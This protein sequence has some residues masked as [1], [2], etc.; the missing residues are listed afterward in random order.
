MWLTMELRHLQHFIAVAE[1]LSFTNAA[2]RVHIVQS[3]L[4]ASIRSLERELGTELFKRTG[5]SVLLTESGKVLLV[6]ARKITQAV[7]AAQDAVAAV[8]GGLRG[9][10]RVGILQSLAFGDLVDVLVDFHSRRPQVRIETR[11]EPGGSR[12]LVKAV[13]D[14]HL[15]VAFVGLP[16]ESPADIDVAPLS[17]EALAVAVPRNHRLYGRPRVDIDELDGEPFVDYPPGWGIRCRVDQMFA[18][19]GLSR[20]IVVEIADCRTAFELALA[21]LGLAFV[22]P[23]SVGV[24]GDTL[25]QVTPA[26]PFEVSIITGIKPQPHAAAR[27]FVD[28]VRAH[29]GRAAA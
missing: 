13:Q 9:L 17:C 24:R 25:T 23:S 4:S 11:V 27:A 22:I 10:V 1:E 12:E 2:R 5:H 6:E 28:V 19:R 20:D 21:G 18:D 16:D 3:A 29:F 7:T 8:E 14:G 26:M 15:D